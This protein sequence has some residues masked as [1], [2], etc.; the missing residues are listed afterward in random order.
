MAGAKRVKEAPIRRQAPQMLLRHCLQG[1]LSDSKY[2][3]QEVIEGENRSGIP[4]SLGMLL[5]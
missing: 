5:V 1:A 2:A 3:G 4:R